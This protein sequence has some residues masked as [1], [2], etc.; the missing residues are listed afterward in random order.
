MDEACPCIGLLVG[1]CE[2]VTKLSLQGIPARLTGPGRRGLLGRPV[3]RDECLP[4]GGGEVF[5]PG[6]RRPRG[7]TTRGS[8]GHGSCHL[9]QAL[10]P[11]LPAPLVGAPPPPCML[12]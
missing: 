9:V 2:G 7:E 12:F 3:P 5:R 1:R 4:L 8:G 6:V 11:P 10:R